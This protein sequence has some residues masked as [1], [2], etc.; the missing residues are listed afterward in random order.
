MAVIPAPRPSPAAWTVDTVRAGLLALTEVEHQRGPRV[1]RWD[2]RRRGGASLRGWRSPGERHNGGHRAEVKGED[3]PEGG[4]AAV[5]TRRGGG[6]SRA[7]RVARF[8]QG[9][10]GAPPAYK[11][12]FFEN[13]VS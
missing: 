9:A 13:Q 3:T 4:A 11:R 5:G 7:G 1:A 2:G 10:S 8:G 12:R 6:R